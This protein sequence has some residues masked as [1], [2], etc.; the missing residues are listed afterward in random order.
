MMMAIPRGRPTCGGH[1]GAPASCLPHARRGS[2]DCA[3]WLN[4]AGCRTIVLQ[5]QILHMCSY[6]W[7]MTIMSLPPRPPLVHFVA[8]LVLSA[9]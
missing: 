9:L 2:L 8:A 4:G 7:D 1:K 5:Q 6:A 3:A